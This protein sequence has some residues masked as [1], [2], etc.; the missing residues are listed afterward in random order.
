MKTTNTDGIFNCIKFGFLF[1][2]G[3]T[4]AG[5]IDS[6]YREKV[7]KYFEKKIIEKKEAK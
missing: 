1:Y 7:I 5:Q 6:C 2:I 4:I 3:F